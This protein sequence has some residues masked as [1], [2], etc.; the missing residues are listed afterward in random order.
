[1]VTVKLQYKYM[2]QCTLCKH[3]LPVLMLQSSDTEHSYDVCTIHVKFQKCQNSR[4]ILK[5]EGL[6]HHSQI[7]IKRHYLCR[8]EQIELCPTRPERIRWVIN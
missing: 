6:M 8:C 1:M 3:V 5:S 2:W 4:F 7:T